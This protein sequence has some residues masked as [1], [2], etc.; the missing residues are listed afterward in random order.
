MG[1]L[2]I[3][4]VHTVPVA[5]VRIDDDPETRTCTILYIR[6]ELGRGDCGDKRLISHVQALVDEMGFPP[7]LP[8]SV[9]GRAGLTR[10]VTM[11]SRW[12]RAA[13]D[14]WLEDWTTPPPV[15][16]TL[17]RKAHEAAAAEMDAAAKG[18]RLI[19]GGRG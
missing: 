1:G 15:A 18:L 10:A 16:A 3:M 14:A 19:R 2:L 5:A 13:V 6:R 17:D 9:K 4:G 7:P 11:N 8:C 12:I